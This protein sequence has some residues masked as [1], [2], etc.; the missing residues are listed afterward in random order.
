[1]NQVSFVGNL[2]ADPVIRGGDTVRANFTVAVNEGA[3][4]KER[5]HFVSC[6]AF[7]TL[8]ENVA[9]SLHKGTRVLVIG[10]LNTYSKEVTIDGETKNMTMTSVTA[11]AVG[12]DL[13]WAQARVAKVARN[14][15]A[16]QHTDETAAD[17]DAAPA[18]NGKVAAAVGAGDDEF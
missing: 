9:V 13:R 2:T 5:T 18:S 4:D 8:G 1:M 3:G 7:G 16:A 17:A 6:T 15:D 12:P 14:S 10:R 11:S